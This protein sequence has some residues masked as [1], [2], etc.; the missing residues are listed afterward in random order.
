MSN[1][2]PL[3]QMIMACIMSLSTFFEG[4]KK[5]LK[6]YEVKYNF[7]PESLGHLIPLSVG[8]RDQPKDK[9]IRYI[10]N[11]MALSDFKKTTISLQNAVNASNT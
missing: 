7:G 8:H 4:L 5:L 1:D 9:E 10:K 2:D 6:K 3:K 11:V